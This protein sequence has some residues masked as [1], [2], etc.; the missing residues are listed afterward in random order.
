MKSVLVI[1]SVGKIERDTYEKNLS[2]LSRLSF[3]QDLT[4]NKEKETALLQADVI[5][6]WN[7]KNELSANELKILPKSK[8]QLLQTV[9]AGVDHL[10][11]NLFS[12]KLEIAT[13]SG[14]YSEPIAEHVL[15]MVLAIVKNILP[16]HL[17][18][19]KGEFN[20][21]S[22]NRQL[23]QSSAL[24]I[25]MG[26]IGTATARLLSQIGV[27][28][29]GVN[30]TG[31]SDLEFLHQMFPLVQLLKALSQYD[32]VVMALP[33]TKTTKNLIGT[34]ELQAM[35]DD[36]I[37]INVARAAIINQ[38]NLFTHLQSHPNFKVGIDTWWIEPFQQQKF[39]LELPFLNLDNVLGSPHNSA[40]VKDSLTNAISQAALNVASYL[41]GKAIKGKL[42]HDEYRL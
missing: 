16:R 4:S 13:N 42:I 23:K 27:K 30:R 21:T 14:A 20:Q 12:S 1:A 3:L 11:F 34:K 7:P 38:Q 41:E 33:L 25:G 26:G 35:K 37:F 32:I 39:E 31:E 29:S 40:I 22:P 17:E 8:A 18:L 5:I 19:T 36:A 24:I 15:A 28:V 9:S 2:S 10:P 6:S